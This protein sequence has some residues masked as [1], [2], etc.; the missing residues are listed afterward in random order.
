MLVVPIGVYVYRGMCTK[1][2]KKELIPKDNLDMRERPSSKLKHGREKARMQPNTLYTPEA[3]KCFI[4]P[5]NSGCVTTY[6][7]F[8]IGRFK[9][10]WFSFTDTAES[11]CILSANEE[12]NYRRVAWQKTNETAIVVPVFFEIENWSL[13]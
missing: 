11:T 9:K 3:S 7:L 12:F 13:R 4:L 6:F 10:I 2:T 8:L 5:N 1:S